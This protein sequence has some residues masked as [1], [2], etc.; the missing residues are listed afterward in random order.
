[1][2]DTLGVKARGLGKVITGKTSQYS[3]D[4]IAVTGNGRAFKRV[5]IVVDAS[6]DTPQIVYRRELTDRGWPM[7]PQILASLRAGEGLETTG[8]T[9]GNG[10]RGMSGGSIR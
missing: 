4:I 7:D 1:V 10:G 2:L 6:G 5:R 8:S 3:A 9:T